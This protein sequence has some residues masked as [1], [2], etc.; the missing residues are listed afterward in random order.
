MIRQ[1]I[2]GL[3]CES[4]FGKLDTPGQVIPVFW[5]DCLYVVYIEQPEY[6]G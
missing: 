5:Y 3:S 1:H 4:K 2:K 6:K